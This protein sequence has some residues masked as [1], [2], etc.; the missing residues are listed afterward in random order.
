MPPTAG[1]TITS[2]PQQQ[3][4]RFISWFRQLESPDQ[5]E[6]MRLVTNE[7]KVREVV[8]TFSG[9]PQEQRQAVFQR[10]GLPNEILSRI[11]PPTATP[12]GDVEVEWKEWDTSQ[13]S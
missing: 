4:E 12:I 3:L 6:L 2:D 13:V 1:D 10:L 8:R 9:M 5:Q 11:S 7:Y